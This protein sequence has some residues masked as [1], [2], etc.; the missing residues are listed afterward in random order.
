[1]K[2]ISFNVNGLRSIMSKDGTTGNKLPNQGQL[3]VLQY[4]AAKYDPDVICLQETR[5]P[6]ECSVDLEMYPFKRIFVSSTKKGYSGVAIFSKTAPL[7]IYENFQH[8][9][10]GRVLCE[11]FQNCFIVNAYVPNSKQDLSRLDYRV[12]TW[13]KEIRVYINALQKKKPVIY[14]ADFNVAPTE[15]DIYKAKGHE[16]SHGFTIEERD[17]FDKLLSECNLIDAFR[18]IRPTERKYSWFSNFG[19]ARYNNNGWRID[20]FLVSEKIKKKIRDCD[21]LYDIYGSDHVP[22]ILDI[23]I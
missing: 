18:L 20:H 12:N 21:I 16:K 15:I 1:M 13:E 11:E 8:N 9:E 19:K 6:D 23:D 10:E 4:I 17:A 14:C 2:I 7:N 3:N 5:C 22:V